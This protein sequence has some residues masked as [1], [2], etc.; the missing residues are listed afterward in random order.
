M[1]IFPA[2]DIKNGNVVRLTQGDYDR[3]SVYRTQPLDVAQNYKKSGA[4]NLHLV[5][6]D[7]AKD[8]KIVN[9][10]VIKQVVENTDMFCEVGGGIRNEKRIEM[11]L[12][13]GVSRIVLGSGAVENPD[14]LQSAIKNFGEKIAVG[15]DVKDG[16]V[17][18]HG[19]KTTTDIQG[20][21]FCVKLRDMG[22][23]TVIYT[24]ISKDG[25]MRGT[26]L[27]VYSKLKQIDGLDTIAS[28]GITYLSEI[29]KLKEIDLYGAILGKA[30][31]EGALDLSE[32]INLV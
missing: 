3:M 5:D 1:E 7:G 12:K 2:I 20:I 25:L 29:K 27:E 14:F 31:F 13:A 24:D 18:I 26:N 11:Y 6:L 10:S 4:K 32:V 16:F 8:G 28:G 9:Y 17:A 30:L 19:W 22:V 23:K 21:D 15:V